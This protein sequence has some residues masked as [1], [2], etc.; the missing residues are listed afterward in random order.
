[1]G[2]ENFKKEFFG[3]SAASEKTNGKIG[4]GDSLVS[5]LLVLKEREKGLQKVGKD[6]RKICWES[7]QGKVV[8]RSRVLIQSKD[9]ELISVRVIGV[10]S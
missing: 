7:V 10:E 6:Y 2:C 9:R 8:T 1:M 4:G 3:C 5:F